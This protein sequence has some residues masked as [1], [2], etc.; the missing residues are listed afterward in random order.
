MQ[1]ISMAG[2]ALI[3]NMTSNSGLASLFDGDTGTGTHSGSKASW[4]GVT[5]AQPTRIQG[6]R[7]TARASGYDGSGNAYS[8]TL[9]LYAKQGLA[10]SS[11]IDGT[12]LAS[13]SLTDP[14]VLTARVLTSGDQ[15]TLYDH[16][17]AAVI[18]GNGIASASE[19]EFYE[20][21]SEDVLYAPRA[22]IS[23]PVYRL[24]G[25]RDYAERVAAIPITTGAPFARGVVYAEKLT[26]IQAGS[27]IKATT[28]FQV[29]TLQPYETFVASTII[30]APTASATDGVELCEEYGDDI[31][32]TGKHHTATRAGF[33][34]ADQDYAEL[35]INTVMYAA[36]TAAGSGHTMRVDRDYG[37]L[38]VEVI[39]P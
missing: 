19:I 4:G 30:A 24:F 33:W 1:P 21:P 11:R 3:G 15:S 9:K 27:V 20:A 18:V 12:E 26:D 10:P 22:V 5:L 36:S 25:G 13:M 16:V 23:A 34:V 14:N 8:V 2:L 38:T 17:W 32:K 39:G 31:E 37:R 6:A 35:W 7:I 29:T 28:D